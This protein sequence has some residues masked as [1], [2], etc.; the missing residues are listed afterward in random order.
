MH[1]IAHWA[2][3]P[4]KGSLVWVRD[5]GRRHSIEGRPG[6]AALLAMLAGRTDEKRDRACKYNEWVWITGAVYIERGRGTGGNR[7]G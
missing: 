6:S 7:A 2:S 1:P 3:G 4:W 5:S